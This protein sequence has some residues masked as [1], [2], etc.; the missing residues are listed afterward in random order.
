M[1][2]RCSLVNFDLTWSCFISLFNAKLFFEGNADSVQVLC[3]SHRRFRCFYFMPLFILKHLATH[4][5]S[6]PYQRL[7]ELQRS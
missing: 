1:V 6:A 5:D 3:T 7:V 2:P 4:V